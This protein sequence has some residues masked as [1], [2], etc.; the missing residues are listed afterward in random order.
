MTNILVEDLSVIKKKVT[1]EVPEERM[2]SLMDAEYRDLKRNVQIKG[3]RKGKVPLNI[4]R[5]YFK[6]QVEADVVRKVIDET[7]EPGLDEKKITAVSVLSLD[8]E[9]LVAGQPFKYIAEIEVP[10]PVEAQGYKGLKLT[11]TVRVL[12]EE[13]VEERLERLRQSMASLNSIPEERGVQT[14]DHLTVDIKAEAEGENVPSLTVSDYHMELGRDFYV[15]GFDANVE[16]MKPD[17]VKQVTMD[18]P[19]DFARK[20]IAGKTAHFEVTLKEAKTKVLP[21]LDDDFAKDLGA[22]ETLDALKEEIRK[23]LTN[24]LENETKRETRDQIIDQLVEAHE[25][26]VPDS[27]VENQVDAFINQSMQNLAMQGIDPKRLPPP[28]QEQRDQVRPSAVRN[29]KAGLILKAIGEQEQIEVSDDEVR[30]SIEK[31][32]E[33]MGLSPDLLKDRWGEDNML[34]E[35]RAG[36]VEDKIYE[37]IQ[38]HAE[39]TEQEP[40]AE[41]EETQEVSEEE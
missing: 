21:D 12:D 40:P 25:F 3:F 7:F 28:T 16:G 27:M 11:K 36:L 29:V 2:T 35:F 33:S 14:G 31:R 24:M 32:A 41:D 9:T 6:K 1:F 39:I 20:D 8:P 17:E 18:L 38:E 37:L 5:S 13:Q 15:P 19:E 4:L 22:Y 34:E 26:E 10:P 23:D 30:E